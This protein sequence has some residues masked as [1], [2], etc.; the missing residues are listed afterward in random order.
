MYL[1]VFGNRL[2]VLRNSTNNTCNIYRPVQL[3]LA[4]RRRYS[5]EDSAQVY[6]YVYRSFTWD[7]FLN[8]DYLSENGQLMNCQRATRNWL[9]E[10]GVTSGKAALY[11]RVP[12]IY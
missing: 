6:V 8:T 3:T 10:M 5:G 1:H 7:I 12:K 2:F 9:V 4:S 11:I